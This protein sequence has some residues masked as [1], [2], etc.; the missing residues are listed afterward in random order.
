MNPASVSDKE[1]RACENCGNTFE[2]NNRKS[3][4][5]RFCSDN[6]RD[7]WHNQ[8]KGNVARRK[9]GQR[10]KSKKL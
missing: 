1:G 2:V 10:V 3:K 5:H 8:Q 4:S 6:C 9:S 7:T